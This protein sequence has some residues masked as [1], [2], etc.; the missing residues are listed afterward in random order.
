M[1]RGSTYQS[2]AIG[3]VA[4]ARAAH[5]IENANVISRLFFAWATPLMA[6]GNARPLDPSDVWPLQ[7]ENQCSIVGRV[8]EPVYSQKHSILWTMASVFG[9]DLLWIFIMQVGKVLG[10]LY[11]PYVLQ[12]IV[13]SMESQGGFDATYCFHLIGSLVVVQLVSGLLSAHSDLQTQLVVVKVTSAL[14]HLLFQ[15]ALRL[16]ATSRRVKSTGEISN[17]FL[18]DIPYIV[19]VSTQGNQILILP[20]QIALILWLLYTVIGWSS[21]VGAA[22]IVLT[23]GSNQV[24]SN[25][26]QACFRT[27]MTQKDIRMKAINETFTAIQVIKLN[28]WE[29]KFAAN[30]ALTYLGPTLVTIVSFA[31]YTLLQHATLPASTL[32]TALSYFNMLR[33]PFSLLAMITSNCMQ[34]LVS[35]QR[36]NEFLELSETNATSGGVLTPATTP[37]DQLQDYALDNVA[38]AIEN[39]RFGWDADINKPLFKDVNLTIKRGE[40]VVVHGSVGEGKSSLCAALLG[41]MHKFQGSIF[42]GGRVAYYSQ[43]AWIQNMTIRENILF[44]H[45][46]DRVKYNN[47]LAAC[48]LSKDLT[49]FPAGDRTEIGQKG[50]NLSGGQKARIS[51]ARACYSDADIFILDSPLSAVDAIVQNEIFTKCFLGLLRHKTVLLVTHSPEIIAS[52]FIDRIVEVKDGK[53][54]DKAVLGRESTDDMPSSIDP[55]AARRGYPVAGDDDNQVLTTDM[56]VYKSNDYNT[57][58]SPSTPHHGESFDVFTPVGP[59]LTFDEDAEV[60]GQ[61]VLDEGRTQGKVS[62]AVYKAYVE[63]AGGWGTLVG[64][65][66][67]SILRQGLSIGSDLWLSVWTST[68]PIE[69]PLEFQQHTPY[70]LGIYAVLAVLAVIATAVA[71]LATYGACVTA[72]KTLFNQMTDALLRAPMRFFDMNPVGRI[73]NRYTTDIGAMDVNIPFQVGSMASVSFRTLC[74]VATAMYMTSYLGLLVLPL[75]YVYVWM[76]R[77][78]VK[79][80]RELERI[81]KT[82]KS[83]LLNLMAESIEGMLVIRAFGDNQRRRFQRMHFR[84]VDATNESMFAKEVVTTWFTLRIQFT[85]AFVVMV[86]SVALVMMRDS[87]SPGLV[88]LALNYI[89]SSLS[90]LEYLIPNFAQFETVMVGPERVVEYANIAPEAPRVISGAVAHDW[91]TNGD[92]AFTNM[93]F[94]YKENDPLVLKDVNVHIQSGEKVGIVGRTGAGKS[95]LTMALFRINELAGGSIKI[96]G[97]DISSIGVKTLR[98]S[99]AIIPQTPVLFKGPLR[100]YLD[101]FGEFGD[102][103]LWGCLQKVRLADRIDS[104]EGKLDSPVEENGENFSVGER[105]MLCMA[106]ALL[107]QARIVVMDEATAAIDHETDQNLQR[108]IRTEFATSTVLTIAHRLDTVLDADRILVFDQGRLAQCDTPAALIGAG[109]GIFF[110]LCHEGGYLDNVVSS[111]L[112]E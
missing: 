54:M 1:A 51:L 13:L 3:G 72:S 36:V 21:F 6:V 67:V 83:P 2:V 84:N 109:A 57:M 71:T 98:S 41:E 22:V 14:Q 60:S 56:P 104:V 106:R 28:A 63:A 24:V 4:S 25:V 19:F 38:V 35:M 85:S 89:F 101:P 93:S 77:Y 33:Q 97:V 76:G 80:V 74:T 43:Q 46:Y 18:S 96:D 15:K 110:E 9:W 34:A 58:L 23:M 107:R 29:E 111:Q 45:P 95:S 53:L 8:F 99:I 50:V 87:L 108:V 47:V 86:V 82:T 7:L 61:L 105:Q 27:L 17:L 12:Q 94:R 39:A 26:I 66:G 59:H 30:T 5:P 64:V 112:V 20:V 49:L 48:A 69:T 81:N 52:K 42:V 73:L 40:F 55:L 75:V 91:P 32:F 88:G 68:V 31:A 100:N 37:N 16:D 65:V 44:G 78:F 10:S 70:Y 62:A 92:I 79:P 90:M 102:A 11:G 103:D